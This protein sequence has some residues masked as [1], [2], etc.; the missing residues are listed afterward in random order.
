MHDEI[1]IELLFNRDEEGINEIKNK[2]GRLFES[3]AYNITGSHE[4]AGECAS[5]TYLALWNNIPPERPENLF[6][7]ACRIARNISLNKYKNNSALK[8]KS[9]YSISLDEISEIIPDETNIEHIISSKELT[10]IIEEFLSLQ[11]KE[12]RVIFVRRYW[13]LDSY[14]EIGKRVGLSV[15]TISVRL[16]RLRNGLKKYLEERGYTI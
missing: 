14:D 16:V 2:Y 6:S 1:I 7:Y 5:D 10:N 15:K 9:N 12:N 8:R 11:S 3:I 4:D 13:F